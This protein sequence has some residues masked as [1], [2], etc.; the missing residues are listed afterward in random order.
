M[1]CVCVFVLF[2][3][4]DLLRL[5]HK[6][7]QPFKILLQSIY[8]QIDIGGMK[9]INSFYQ[10][11]SL[12]FCLLF[13]PWEI[14]YFCKVFCAWV[15]SPVSCVF[16]YICKLLRNDKSLKSIIIINGKLLRVYY[17]MPNKSYTDAR[18]HFTNVS[19]H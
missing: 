5:E 4:N 16:I 19:R 2:R 18:L 3:S 6:I 14:S 8:F 7:E 15:S 13:S 11:F 12:F 9:D 17:L 10:F 1:F